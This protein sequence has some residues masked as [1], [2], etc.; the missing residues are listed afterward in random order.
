MYEEYNELTGSELESDSDGYNEDD[1]DDKENS[2]GNTVHKP[3]SRTRP[4]PVRVKRKFKNT[5]QTTLELSTAKITELL[6]PF[7]F[8]LPSLVA[9]LAEYPELKPYITTTANQKNTTVDESS[10]ESSADE[11]ED[12]NL[13]PTRPIST[14]KPAPYPLTDQQYAVIEECRQADTLLFTALPS[15]DVLIKLIAISTH[16]C[17]PFFD[18]IIFPNVENVI[19]SSRTQENSF[20]AR[21]EAASD[22]PRSLDAQIYSLPHPISFALDWL[23]YDFSLCIHSPPSF[24]KRTWIEAQVKKGRVA[25]SQTDED[26]REEYRDQYNDLNPL[27]GTVSVGKILGLRSISYHNVLP[28]DR[29]EFRTDIETYLYF[30]RHEE[31]VTREPDDTLRAIAETLSRIDFSQG[32]LKKL[33]LVDLE[34]LADPHK[35]KYGPILS[36]KRLKRGSDT[37]QRLHKHIRAVCR[38]QGR[39]LDASERSMLG[40]AIELQVGAGSG[41]VICG[42]CVDGRE[43]ISCIDDIC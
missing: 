15:F 20:K 16:I 23:V 18:Q 21:Y 8:A 26:M 4:K 36:E 3:V 1:S 9:N 12:G 13:L 29:P 35:F 40:E 33:N 31:S 17:I 14:C 39:T 2:T 37:V 6:K 11:D 5:D 42:V 30:G 38:Q 34:Y 41:G 43:E 24:F 25:S 7:R 32:P 28:G 19:F 10:D 27:G 22:P